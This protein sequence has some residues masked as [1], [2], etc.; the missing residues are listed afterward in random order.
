MTMTT[1]PRPVMIAPSTSAAS[2]SFGLLMQTRG[3]EQLL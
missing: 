2:H 3:A 1:H